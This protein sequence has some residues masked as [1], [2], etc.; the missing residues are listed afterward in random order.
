MTIAIGKIDTAPG[1]IDTAGD[2]EAAR[3][4]F[5]SARHKD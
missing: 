5:A 1:G 2:L 3:Q 4:R